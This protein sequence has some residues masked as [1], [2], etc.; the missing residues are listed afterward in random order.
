MRHVRIPALNNAIHATQ[1][2]K[3]LQLFGLE[4]QERWL[5]MIAASKFTRSRREPAITETEAGAATTLSIYLSYHITN[6]FSIKCTESQ[7]FSGKIRACHARAPCSIHGCDIVLSA[8][9]ILFDIFCSLSILSERHAR[10]GGK[11]SD[12]SFGYQLTSVLEKCSTSG[13][14]NVQT[15]WKCC[16]IGYCVCH[17]YSVM[18]QLEHPMPSICAA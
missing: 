15:T 11:G 10:S 16:I 1:S 8:W 4:F 2:L 9:S 13:N 14:H 17:D 18:H 3:V 6:G 12:R 7:W 5:A